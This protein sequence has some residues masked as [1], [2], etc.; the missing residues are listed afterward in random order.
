VYAVVVQFR[1]IHPAA[2]MLVSIG[3]GAHVAYREFS[4]R[5]RFLRPDRTPGIPGYHACPCLAR[6]GSTSP[7]VSEVEQRDKPLDPNEPTTLG[8]MVALTDSNWHYIRKGDGTEELYAFRSDS[9]EGDN[10]IDD[11]SPQMQSLRAQGAARP[12]NLP[13]QGT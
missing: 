5:S 10:R 8:P 11:P 6:R 2:L 1:G 12:A 3:V 9:T 7:V 13:C 4:A